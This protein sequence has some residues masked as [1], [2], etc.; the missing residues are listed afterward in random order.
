MSRSEFY[1]PPI[2]ALP[3]VADLP[4]EEIVA[5]LLQGVDT[6]AVFF[7]LPAGA[8]I[9]PHSHCEQWGV[10]LDG[11]I[12]LTIGETTHDFTKGDTYYIPEGTV[13][14]GT[15]KGGCRALDVFFEAGRYRPQK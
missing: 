15:T 5:H 13:H 1:P 7:D 8:S 12:D 9:P 11:Q 6:Q 14:S 4:S 3:R 2:K 10:V